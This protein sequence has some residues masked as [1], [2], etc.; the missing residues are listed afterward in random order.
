[1][2]VVEVH[3][4]RCKRQ[5]LFATL[6]TALRYLVETAEE[7]LEVIRHQLAVPARQVI[8]ALVN[9]AERARPPFL[10]E[11]TAEALV[12]TARARPDELGEFFLLVFESCRHRGLLG[13]FAR[14]SGLSAAPCN[15][16]A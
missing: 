5:P 8:D 4:H 16:L 15:M 10:V 11:V 7:P 14:R 2:V 9:G 6:W 13:R 12:P 3:D 1:M